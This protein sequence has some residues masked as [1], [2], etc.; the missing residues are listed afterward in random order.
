M[1]LLDTLIATTA[2]PPSVTSIAYRPIAMPGAGQGTE[3]LVVSATIADAEYST[4]VRCDWGAEPRGVIEARLRHTLG[5]F[6]HS[7]LRCQR[8]PTPTKVN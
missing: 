6:E 4:V 8:Q 5:A 3:W 1:D 2:M 7:A